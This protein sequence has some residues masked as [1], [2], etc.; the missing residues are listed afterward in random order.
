MQ[1]VMFCGV[2]LYSSETLTCTFSRN[3]LI[4]AALLTAPLNGS[5]VVT[6]VVL[7]YILLL[8]ELTEGDDTRQNMSLFPL[9]LPAPFTDEHNGIRVLIEQ[10]DVANSE[11]GVLFLLALS[12]LG[13]YSII[14]AS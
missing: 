12:S 7:G 6:L 14:L 3:V 5:L 13:V 8:L 9:I 1:V 11:Y 2:A 4:A 10:Y